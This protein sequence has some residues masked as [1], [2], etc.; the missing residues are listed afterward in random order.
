VKAEVEDSLDFF[1]DYYRAQQDERHWYGFWDYG[2]VMHTQDD[3]RK[4]WRYDIGGY[5]W[6]NSEISPDMWL[7]QQYLHTNRA[8]V[9][10]FAEAM[11][12]KTSDVNTYHLGPWAGLGSRHNVQHWGDSAK[13]VRISNA[14]YRRY[15]YYLTADEHTGDLLHLLANSE[16]TFLT[17][18]PIRKIRNPDEEYVPDRNALSIGFGTDW[19]ALVSGWLAE[20]ERRGPDWEACRQKVLGTMETIAAQPSGFAQGSGLYDMDTGRFQIATAPV[21]ERSNLSNAFGRIEI[22][23]ELALQ[24]DMPEFEEEWLRYSRFYTATSAE[25][26]AEYGGRFADLFIYCYARANAFVYLRTGDESQAKHAWHRFR[27]PLKSWEIRPN[28]DRKATNVTETLN[29]T[30]WYSIATNEIAQWGQAAVQI[31]ALAGDFVPDE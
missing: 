27:N 1:F 8:D 22:C 26:E 18:D 31:L 4:A 23:N 2:D 19:G 7:W 9:F 16:E 10:R 25:Q 12:R 14:N 3:D 17:L 29:P 11:T 28:P 20:W 6:D 30:T 21:V 15:H 13:Q 24:V 5:A